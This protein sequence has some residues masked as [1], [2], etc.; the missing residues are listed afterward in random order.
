[1]SGFFTAPQVGWG[2]S[3]VEQL[4]GIGARR[5]LLVVDPAV[6]S[7]PYVRRVVEELEKTDTAVEI[8]TDVQIEPT[9][10]ALESGVE[11]A[12]R[13]RPEWILALGGGSTIDTA[14]GIWAR[15]ARPELPI[16]QVNPLVDLGLRSAARFVAIPT[17]S[18]SGSEATWA[19][20]L[21]HGDGRL[22]E[23][24]HRELLPD[25]ALV[26]GAFTEPVPPAVRA[27]TAG[28]LIAHAFEAIASEWASPFSDAAAREA[29]GLAVPALPRAAR[30]PADPEPRE[31]LALA[32]TLAGLAVANA[33]LGVVH[34]LAHAVGGVTAVPHARLAAALLPYALEFNFP[35]ARDR[36]ATLAPILGGAAV[37][38]R[39]ALPER[40]RTV[41]KTVGLPLS[42]AAAGV[43]ADLLAAERGRV[44]GWARA[45]PALVGNPRLPTDEELGR[46]LDVAA[47]GGPV[48]F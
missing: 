25:W 47:V 11:R 37:Q 18:G 26:D 24:G 30:S 2:P 14:K 42:L 3:A 15:Y 29:I 22:L 17:T 1:M 39:S 36:Y 16:E 19:I 5:A 48:P 28:D 45:S 9:V 40:L 41:W 31:A 10:A 34:A 7:R 27:E 33:Q 35:A 4:S 12:R 23:V 21:R 44:V 8:S 43:P 20:H 38:N 6:A 46:L 32:A 13:H